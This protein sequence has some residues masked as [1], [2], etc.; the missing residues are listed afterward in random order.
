MNTNAIK[1]FREI[2]REDSTTSKA[3]MKLQFESFLET[4]LNTARQEG[5]DRVLESFCIVVKNEL[6]QQRLDGFSLDGTDFNAVFESA[7]K[8]VLTPPKASARNQPL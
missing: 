8:F 6:K 2:F 5:A 3:Q 7:K 4:E 1:R